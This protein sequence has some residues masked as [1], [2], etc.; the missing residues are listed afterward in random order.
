MRTKE[1]S[2][3]PLGSAAIRKKIDENKGAEAWTLGI[4]C[5]QEKN[6]ENKGAE[7]WTL[8]ISCNQEKNRLE[9]GSR[10]LDPRDLLKSETNVQS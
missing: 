6:D 5:N 9:Q 7:A 2:P 10:G 8:G 1:Q 4:S 3:G